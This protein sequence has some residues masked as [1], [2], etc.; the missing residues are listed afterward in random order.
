MQ[1]RSRDTRNRLL[2]AALG[3]FARK[4]YEASSVDDICIEA[5]VSKGAFY[6]HFQTKQALFLA[7]LSSWLQGIDGSL[8]YV[9]K[10]SVP[11]TLLAMTDL[12]PGILLT[13]RDQLPM[14]LEF[15]LQ[16]S[17]DEKVWKASIEP[18]QHFREFF[19][20]LIA[21]GTAEGS[22]RKVDSEVA[23]Q[24]IL[25]MAVGILLQALLEPDRADWGRTTRQGMQIIMKGLAA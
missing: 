11:K 17:R 9:R 19:A 3:Q 7:L 13:A 8:A 6:H 23:A 2:T 5:G 12:L 21:E 24:T 14:F 10:Q 15:W 20:D 18:Y 1:Q 25:S 22:F 4:G 16:A